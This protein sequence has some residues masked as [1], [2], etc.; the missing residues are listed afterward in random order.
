M[1]TR[2]HS[3]AAE[4]TSTANH[5]PCLGRRVIDHLRCISTQE[6]R[7]ESSQPNH[8]TTPLILALLSPFLPRYI[9]SLANISLVIVS[10]RH[11]EVNLWL[12]PS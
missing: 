6:W 11:S 10:A 4:Y 3:K 12:E 8:G 5:F 7:N 2:Q 9:E 1:E